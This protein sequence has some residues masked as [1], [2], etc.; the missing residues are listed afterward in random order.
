MAKKLTILLTLAGMLFLVA[1]SD[2]EPTSSTE[3]PTEAF[4]PVEFFITQI[5]VDGRENIGDRYEVNY[6]QA[7]G[8]SIDNGLTL[9]FVFN[10]E[11]FDFS[12][13][14]VTT[15][16]DGTFA[17]TGTLY[18]VGNL[19]LS[20]SLVLTHYF[21]H[22]T[23]PISGFTFTDSNGE[24]KWFVF[25]QSQM[26]GEIY[27]ETFDWSH[28]HTLAVTEDNGFAHHVDRPDYPSIN[29]PDDLEPINIRIQWLDELPQDYVEW[30]L[31]YRENGETLLIAPAT[32]MRDFAIIDVDTNPGSVMGPRIMGVMFYAGDL[33]PDRP[34]VIHSFLE[35]GCAVPRTGFTFIDEAG[36]RRFFTFMQSQMDGRFYINEFTYDNFER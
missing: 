34:L 3:P 29:L 21:G 16:E 13:I 6:A 24:S 32:T 5:D 17:K 18:E 31:P 9:H 20:R 14:E 19:T 27:W 23:L 2:D 10:Q 12:F 15:L 28:N 1:C 11:V 36:M 4:V 22:G 7:H 25:S 8:V 35:R 30:T 26:D 33:T